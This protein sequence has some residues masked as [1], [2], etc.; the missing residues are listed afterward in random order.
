MIISL[1]FIG[2]WYQIIF[3]FRTASVGGTDEAK[4]MALLR[5]LSDVIA[6]WPYDSESCSLELFLFCLKKKCIHIDRPWRL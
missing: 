5:C 2:R 1:I 6:R 3:D 4:E